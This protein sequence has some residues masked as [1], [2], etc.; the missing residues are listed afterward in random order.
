MDR[1]EYL[2]RAMDAGHYREKK[3]VFNVFT[4]RQW[5]P[6]PEKGEHLQLYVKDGYYCTVD[7]EGHKDE[8]LFITEGG[9]PIPT[10]KTLFDISEELK[11]K[12]FS[13]PTLKQ[14]IVTTPGIL[15]INYY[16][17][18]HAFGKK[19]DYINDATDADNL[20]KPVV[21][22][23]VD[24]IPQAHRTA[25]D[26]DIYTDEAVKFL[27]ALVTF[28][29]FAPLNAP[30]ATPYTMTVDPEILKLRD[31]LIEENKDR[32]TDPVVATQ[33]QDQLVAKDKAYL[34]KD[35]NKGFYIAAKT[36]DARKKVNIINGLNYNMA[37]KPHFVPNSLSEGMRAEDM[38]TLFDGLRN[39]SFNRGAM[40]A[41]G[42][43]GVK[44][45]LR[46]F[47][48]SRVVGDDCKVKYGIEIDSDE[49][50]LKNFMSRY[51]IWDGKVYPVNEKT[52]P[53]LKG[54][55][56]MLRSPYSCQQ[57]P[58]GRDFCLTCLGELFKGNESAIAVATSFVS[59]QLLYIFMKMKH[60]TQA[61]LAKW[62]PLETLS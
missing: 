37:G 48:A 47:N 43:E 30:S 61:K 5:E 38:P 17:I 22:R 12:A 10:S 33:I 9:K 40:T 24:N 31:K 59:S 11:L 19:V 45:L 56:L 53:A 6:A 55:S 42:G 57:D 14:D 15:L 32:L 52:I 16:C 2:L 39:G 41:L 21:D 58:E 8:F 49:K 51:V 62:A 7:E 20:V 54:K 44:F 28:S 18:I 34:D 46:V 3:W 23:I 36:L 29:S 25:T 35:P 60:G 1:I 4:I 50:T 26:R 27:S 13:V